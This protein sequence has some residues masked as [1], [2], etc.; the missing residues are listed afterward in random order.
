MA[1]LSIELQQTPIEPVNSG[2]V[3]ILR[4]FLPAHFV[5][6]NSRFHDTRARGLL[7]SGSN[8]LIENNVIERTALAGMEF[9]QELATYGSAD[10]VS[11]VVVRNNTI[12]DVCFADGDRI[13]SVGAIQVMNRPA[14]LPGEPLPFVP[15]I[16]AHHN[17]SIVGN[18]IDGCNSAG[19]VLNGVD[20]GEVRN[21]V[22]RNTN[23]ERGGTEASFKPGES[24]NVPY[25]ITVMNSINVHLDENSVSDLGPHAKGA[26]GDVGTF[27]VP[28]KNG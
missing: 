24:M 19:I 11:N 4:K 14:V 28:E 22:V 16:A 15:W 1:I 10:W 17:I 3:V 5:I 26:E 7:I 12:R 21:N 13:N 2:D 20:G 8:G 18:T 9:L 25:A 27:P 23:L 6:R